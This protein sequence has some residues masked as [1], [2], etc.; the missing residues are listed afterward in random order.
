[1]HIP[2]PLILF[3]TLLS[4]LDRTT[5]V[6]PFVTHAPFTEIP[7]IL[8]T[9]GWHYQSITIGPLPVYNG[10][11]TGIYEMLVEAEREKP[12]R[13]AD[14]DWGKLKSVLQAWGWHPPTLPAKLLRA[15]ETPPPEPRAALANASPCMLSRADDAA[16]TPASACP[17]EDLQKVSSALSKHGWH[18]EP[19]TAT[20]AMPSSPGP[21]PELEEE[22]EEMKSILT[23]WGWVHDGSSRSVS[24]FVS[25]LFSSSYG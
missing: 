25:F 22:V 19:S 5:A 14:L 7:H 13:S 11:E 23:K 4:N 12:R 17:E 16:D 20:P 8:S 18:F 24:P 10:E 1:M 6:P 21:L 9:A 2:T 3:L 15:R